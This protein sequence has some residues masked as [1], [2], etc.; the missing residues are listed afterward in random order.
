MRLKFAYS[1]FRGLA[2]PILPLELLGQSGWYQVW[3]FVD[4]GAT[5][6]L[7]GV[8][9]A[10]RLGIPVKSGQ[11][12]AVIFGDGKQAVAYVQDLEMRLGSVAMRLPIGFTNELRVGFNILGRKGL[13][14][15]FTVCFNDRYQQI[16]FTRIR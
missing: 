7:F 14:D 6:S 8:D 10:Q 11:R 15:V 12:V 3:A 13:F 2:V 4:S 16:S 5:Y 9:V 1:L